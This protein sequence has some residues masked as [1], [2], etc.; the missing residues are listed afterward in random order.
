MKQTFSVTGERLSK[1]LWT[2]LVAFERL[3]TKDEG[4]K[5]HAKKVHRG[6]S[7]RDDPECLNVNVYSENIFPRLKGG[8]IIII[9]KKH[10][11]SQKFFNFRN[12]FIA[13]FLI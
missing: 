2:F 7:F 11:L 9:C 13:K 12:I 8:K 10:F 4:Q 5:G 3:R 1:M 6:Q